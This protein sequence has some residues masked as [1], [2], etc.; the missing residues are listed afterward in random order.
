MAKYRGP[1]Y[2]III[3]VITSIIGVACGA[4]Y[5][6]TV[7][8]EKIIARVK[9]REKLVAAVSISP[10]FVCYDAQDKHFVGY[11]VDLIQAIADKIGV[12][13][14]IKEVQFTSLLPAVKNGE[15]DL[16]LGAIHIRDR[17]KIHLNISKP[18]F[19]TG[20]VLVMRKETASSNKDLN[21]K[22]V[23]VKTGGTSE[24]VA[25]ELKNKQVNIIVKHYRETEDYL[26]DLERGFIDAALNDM[27][28]QIAYNRTHGNLVIVGE[29]LADYGLGVVMPKEDQDLLR[30][31]DAVI[32]EMQQSGQ[33][34][35]LYNKWL[36]PQ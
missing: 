28:H 9:T 10:P 3:A 33:S 6:N 11:D 16:A 17:R 32:E 36:G 8:Q 34:N 18:Y 30:I 24:R 21:G 13:V 23:G 2:L 15:A 27:A 25:Q 4:Y 35:N 1:A 22:V 5:Y 19:Q 14:E 12:P 31:V 7:N 26:Q 29:P 20:I